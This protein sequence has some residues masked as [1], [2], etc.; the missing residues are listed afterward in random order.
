[1][2]QI[3]QESI[4]SKYLYISLQATKKVKQIITSTVEARQ[5]KLFLTIL[6][7]GISQHPPPPS[8]PT[9]TG[10]RSAPTCTRPGLRKYLQ[11][12]SRSTDCCNSET[13][14]HRI[15]GE[16]SVPVT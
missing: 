8:P 16:R 14:C 5:F 11:T 13:K 1:M 3:I 7:G 10:F 6:G 9:T 2:L 15:I 4:R 12:R